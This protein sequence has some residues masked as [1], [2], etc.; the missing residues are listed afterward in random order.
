MHKFIYLCIYTYI[1]YIYYIYTLYLYVYTLKY[2]TDI[3]DISQKVQR[4]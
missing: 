1:L 3:I 4:W 2:Y